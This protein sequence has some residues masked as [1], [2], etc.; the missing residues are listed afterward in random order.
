MIDADAEDG[1]EASKARRVMRCDGLDNIGVA[2]LRFTSAPRGLPHLGGGYPGTGHG[3][4]APHCL[5]VQ[6]LCPQP[7]SHR[8]DRY[9]LARPAARPYA[10]TYTTPVTSTC[11]FPAAETSHDDS[12]A[13]AWRQHHEIAAWAQ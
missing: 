11:S 8:P 1:D 10:R 5:L 6:A 9:R 4:R 2:L 3:E 12:V 13:G 7:P